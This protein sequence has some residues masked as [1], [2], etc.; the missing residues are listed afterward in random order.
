MIALSLAIFTG[1]F[2]HKNTVDA[3]ENAGFEDDFTRSKLGSKLPR[4]SN[5]R[6]VQQVTGNPRK[7]REIS[8]E[9]SSRQIR[10]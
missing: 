10:S 4:R 3:P 2:Q 9:R 5:R 8:G 7:R 6:T 1:V